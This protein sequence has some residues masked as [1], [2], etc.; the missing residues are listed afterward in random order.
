MLPLTEG[1]LHYKSDTHNV[2]DG[3]VQDGT[4][5]VELLIVSSNINSGEYV[6]I[7][8]G[9][10]SGMLATCMRAINGEIILRYF[11]KRKK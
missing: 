2:I 8:R 4:S 7:V 10:F 1:K 3:K 9:P 5:A 6:Q 11:Q